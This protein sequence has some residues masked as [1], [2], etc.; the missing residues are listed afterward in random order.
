M[1]TLSSVLLAASLVAA[2]QNDSSVGAKGGSGA[3]ATNAA[4]SGDL[5]SRV[6]KL[7]ADAAKH[8]EA[9]DFLDKVY[10][11]Q[12]QQAEQQEREE[13]AP[14][15]IFAVDITPDVAAGQVE[16]PANAP[17]TIVEAFDFACPYCR[18]VSDTLESLVKSYDGK[19]R[20]VYKNMVVHPQV[21]TAAHL[22]S[23]AAAKQGKYPQFKNELWTKGF[24]AYAAAR[25]PGKLSEDNVIAIAKGIGLNVDKLKTDMKSDECKQRL[26]A[27][28]AELNKFHVNS[29]PTLFVNGT[30]VGGALPE[31]Q[32]K[33]M[34]DE[35]LKVVEQSGVPADQYYDKEI[36]GKGE[37]QF[38]SKK[39]PKPS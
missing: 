39:D 37:K 18:Q 16:G 29:T 13:P 10:A 34:I 12:K 15:A 21:A 11:Q 26:A 4:P 9:L 25:D 33:Q 24:D 17:V 5:E 8:A 23:C 6:K 3:A 36:M 30:H 28:M 31:A 38:R 35:K 32:F 20:V 27:D 14:D 19:V 22:A 2:C 7:E 1:K